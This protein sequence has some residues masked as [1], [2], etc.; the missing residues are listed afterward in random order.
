[1]R[2]LPRT[3][4]HSDSEQGVHVPPAGSGAITAGKGLPP[5]LPWC[6]FGTLP[7]PLIMWPSASP[8]LVPWAGRGL[9]PPTPSS[10]WKLNSSFLKEPDFCPA[11]QEQWWGVLEAKPPGMSSACWWDTV[12]KPF[13]RDFCQRFAKTVAHKRRETRN[14][15]Q[16]HW[17]RLWRGG[18]GPSFLGGR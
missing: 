16:V 14:F 17:P 2:L 13:F 15:F 18:G 6:Q 5:C 9:L 11:F 3:T 4:L 7:Q 10:Y 8:L 1:M 12:A